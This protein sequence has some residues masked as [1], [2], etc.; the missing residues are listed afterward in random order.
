MKINR[1]ARGSITSIAGWGFKET[2][3]K[4]R[5]FA[6]KKNLPYLSFE[7][8][9]L[10]SLGLGVQGAVQ[11]TLI[12]DYSG[13]Y[14][15]SFQVSDLETNIHS[16][17]TLSD[18][19]LKRSA[20]C[21]SGLR[22]NRLSKYNSA[23]EKAISIPER[24]RAV[25]VV[26]QTFG[27]ASI[28]YG[29]ASADSFKAMLE[30]AISENFE[31]EI[32]VKIHPDVLAGKKQGHLLE[33][34]RE[35]D[36]RILA[37]DINPWSVL[38][39]VDHVYVVTSQLGFEGLLAGKKV[40]CFGMPFYAGW[41]LTDD[42]QVCERRG[43]S[44]T[45][46]QVFY[47]AYIQYCRYI[48]PYTGVRC[49][50]EDT[51]RLIST[52]KKH[53]ERHRGNWS[54]LGF[55]KWKKR[56]IPDFL[57]MG[58]SVRFV[59]KPEEVSKQVASGDNL[60][61][62][63]SRVS[64]AQEVLCANNGLKM[65]RMEDGFLRSVGLGADLVRPLSLVIDASGIYY[66]SSQPSDLENLLNNHNFDS[67]LLLRA[68]KVR[69][70][71]VQLRLS[72]Y[73]VGVTSGLA[74][75]TDKRVVLVPGQ[76]ETDAS[77]AKGSPVIQTNHALLEAVRSDNP[78]AFIIYKPHPDVLSGGRYGELSDAASGLYDQLITDISITD[79]FDV[80]DEVHTMSSLSG[81]EALLRNKRVV[82]YG[83][84]F[85]A[86][87]GLT[88]DKLS[89]ER[90]SRNLTLDQLVAATLI[91][92]P[93]YVEPD[94]G[95]VCDIETIIHILHQRQGQVQGPSIKTRLYRAYRSV[96]EGKR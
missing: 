38:D 39:V 16:S 46:E 53:L 2:T 43:V 81:F 31:A 63:S 72:K 40:T 85:Y 82:T 10:R 42:R 67:E 91:L 51:I 34:A 64:A 95:Q 70:Q 26:D 71:L 27:D 75:P 52:Q 54:V 12:V 76:V 28:E 56:F 60:L 50:L 73:N 49:E 8:G 1:S 66:D 6:D 93:I 58:A 19:E 47:A 88:E 9:F 80:I 87:W 13:I 65:W 90:R 20:N 57:G 3:A 78:D 11:H 68:A 74:L 61:V 14:Y 62:W 32:L 77:I 23:P 89:C 79:L 15:N 7:D 69:E 83:L 84:P 22:S 30:A 94:S 24:N 59:D 33:A 25:L 37:E 55:S 36:C 21:I 17:I 44:R 41:G 35:Y 48:N 5:N 96:F 45:L 86:G 18:A 92:Y 4:A 29:L